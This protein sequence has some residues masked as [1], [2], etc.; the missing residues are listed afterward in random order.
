MVILFMKH[1]AF[2]QENSQNEKVLLLKQ[3]IKNI[4][5]NRFVIKDFY[6]GC[7]VPTISSKC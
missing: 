3:R 5:D 7:S 6:Q 2:E 1:F 4:T